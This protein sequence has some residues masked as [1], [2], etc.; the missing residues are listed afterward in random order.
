VYF[1][2]LNSETLTLLMKGMSSTKINF[3]CKSDE[4][5]R[6]IIE[7][8]AIGWQRL[9]KSPNSG[10][11]IIPKVFHFI[12]L[13]SCLPE[14]FTPLIDSWKCRHSSWEVK[15]WSDADVEQLSLTNRHLFDLSMNFGM[16]SDILRY[17][18]LQKFGGVYVDIDYECIANIENLC[19][20]CHFFAG[21]SNTGV[22]EVNNGLIG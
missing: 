2:L 18:I 3:W 16:K 21:L 9:R 19:T 14:K 6:G 11:C 5:F 17:E 8:T 7:E 10:T 15:I 12:W 1:R 4:E 22:L 13:G 20:D